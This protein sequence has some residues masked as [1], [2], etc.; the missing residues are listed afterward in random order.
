MKSRTATVLMFA[1][2]AIWETIRFRWAAIGFGLIASSQLIFLLA[3]WRVRDL[4]RFGAALVAYLGLGLLGFGYLLSLFAGT[5]RTGAFWAALG[6]VLLIGG[7]TVLLARRWL[8]GE[9]SAGG[10]T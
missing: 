1:G 2:L 10:S 7:P 5:P 9:V 6:A 3:I 4:Q 8:L